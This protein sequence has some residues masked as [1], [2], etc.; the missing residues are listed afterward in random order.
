MLNFVEKGVNFNQMKVKCITNILKPENVFKFEAKWEELKKKRGSDGVKPQMCYHGTSE[1]N[2]QNIINKGLL[3]PGAKSG[4]A[5][6][7]DTGYWGEG[8]YLSPNASLSVGYCRTGKKLFICSALMGRIFKCTQL[9]HGGK[10][11]TGFDS[12]QDPSGNEWIIFDP[13]QVLCCYVVEFC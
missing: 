5:H 2:I 10:L 1:Q 9:I 7:T 4:I 11:T 13:S 8:I 6:A 12:H 3:V